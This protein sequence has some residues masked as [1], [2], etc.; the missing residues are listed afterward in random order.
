MM[1]WFQR[2]AQTQTNIGRAF[3]TCSINK[4]DYG[5]CGYF[6]WVDKLIEWLTNSSD[7]G[8]E[9]LGLHHGREIGRQQAMDRDIVS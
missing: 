8:I 7:E 9:S 6:V 5:C 2:V 3:F 4:D 1:G